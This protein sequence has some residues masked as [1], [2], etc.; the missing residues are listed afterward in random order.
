MSCMPAPLLLQH[1][2]PGGLQLHAC[3]SRHAASICPPVQ[4]KLPPRV[5]P[6]RAAGAAGAAASS[7]TDTATPDA[8]APGSEE[9][10]LI[11]TGEQQRESKADTCM[12]Y[13]AE[14]AARFGNG[15]VNA[16]MLRARLVHLAILRLLGAPLMTCAAREGAERTPGCG[17]I[18]A[19][20]SSAGLLRQ[21]LPDAWAPPWAGACEGCST[22]APPRPWLLWCHMVSACPILGGLR[23]WK[24]S[25]PLQVQHTKTANLPGRGHNH[26][27]SHLCF[28]RDR[29]R[30]RL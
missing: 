4:V 27:T 25:T 16:R 3:A 14:T 8:S 28:S 19:V 30:Q 11:D 23:T 7:G 6:N 1:Q 20:P 21:Q 18:L 2:A 12:R 10:M 5:S 22:S 13:G 24:G 9:D 17:I 15:W 26:H 29:R